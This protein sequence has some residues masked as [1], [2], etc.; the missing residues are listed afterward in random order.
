MAVFD[1]QQGACVAGRYLT[2]GQRRLHLVREREQPDR[3]GDGAAAAPDA[4][5]DRLLRQVELVGEAAEGEGLFQRAEVLALQVLDQRQL[6]QRLGRRFLDDDRH[7]LE[8]GL[9]RSQQTPLAGDELV[10]RAAWL[11]GPADD[12]RLD[13]AVLADAL[14]QLGDV[15]R[16]E[17]GAWLVRVRRDQVDVDLFDAAGE[18]VVGAAGGALGMIA[19][20][21]RPRPL[22]RDV[23]AWPRLWQDSARRWAGTTR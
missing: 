4:R 22:R 3:V 12:E 1:G 9:A 14:G 16:V 18:A 13:D 17:D 2:R 10:R 8:P 11:R 19:S 21:P 7:A 15:R 23:I 5:G 20:S 6:E